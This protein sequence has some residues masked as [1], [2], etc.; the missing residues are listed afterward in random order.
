M[1]PLFPDQFVWGTATA[2][3]QI[4]G[5]WNE[6]G[7]GPSIWDNFC[8]TPGH[9]SVPPNGL[10]PTGDVACDHYHRW[11]EDVAL[12]K[13][14]GVK[15]YR[16]SLSWPRL[17][18]EG[19]GRLNPQGVAF[20]RKLLFALREA[21]IQPWVTLFHWDLPSALQQRGGWSNR[22]SVAWFSDYATLVVR[23]FGDLV[24]HWITFNEPQ[25]FIWAGLG[26]GEHAPG[27][28][29][30]MP[31]VL[32]AGHHMLMAH[33]Q[34]VRALRAGA[35]GACQVGYAPI[36]N[37]KIPATE[38]PEDIEAARSY[39]FG[40][41][42]DALWDN[43]WWYDPAIL[44]SYPADGL[45][46]FAGHLPK[47]W[48]NDLATMHAPLDF[49]G[50]NIYQGE[51]IRVGANGKPQTAHYG[52]G[53]PITAFKWNMTPNC[54][55]WGPRFFYERYRLPIYIT[56]N[57]LSNADWVHTDGTVPDPQRIDFLR[58][59]LGELAR[60]MAEGADVRGYFHWSFMDNFEWSHGYKERFGLVHV[61]FTTLK[62][63]PKQSF[64]FYRAIIQSNGGSL[65]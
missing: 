42:P 10:S 14:L 31:E 38:S 60:G 18:P 64:A 11:P 30:D 26:C 17:L 45:G 12:M 34:A 52:D 65:V 33:G 2:A 53:H 63:T 7:K 23:E 19:T 3:Y 37:T 24:S 5:A 61:D 22:D 36:G 27:Y 16:L 1:K 55:R 4:E 62:R 50:A 51:A 41:R 25:C 35:P 15:A 6:D 44:G 58:R 20:Y 48:E 39:M 9:I 54:L 43:A 46:H 28:K 57:G 49:M 8:H 29:L 21:G 40:T 59:Y 47:G 56:E 13:E 32:R